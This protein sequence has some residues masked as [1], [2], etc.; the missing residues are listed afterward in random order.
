MNKLIKSSTMRYRNFIRT[1]FNR[2]DIQNNLFS[3]R[4][5]LKS[6]WTAWSSSWDSLARY[7]DIMVPMLVLLSGNRH[8]ST[9]IPFPSKCETSLL[10]WDDFPLRSSPSKTIR[11]PLEL[12]WCML[13]IATCLEK[14]LPANLKQFKDVAVL[15]PNF[16]HL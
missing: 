11:A 4:F 7:D 16:L 12:S 8:A 3:Q 15:T 10:H 6:K 5:A 9:E 13:S 14:L 2:K 1:Q